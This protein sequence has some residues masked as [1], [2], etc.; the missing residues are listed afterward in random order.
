MPR[1]K[2]PDRRYTWTQKI[3]IPNA[4]GVLQAFFVSFGEYADGRLGEVWIEAHKEGTLVRGMAGALA[5]QA[6]MAIQCGAGLEEV[7][8]SMRYLDFPPH[9]LVVG[10]T[11]KVTHC[12]SLPDYIA[13][14][15]ELAYLGFS[16]EPL[17][18]PRSVG[19]ARRKVD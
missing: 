10:E 19:F 13:Q 9:G 16:T 12:T 5:R 3:K 6:S 18:N 11:T 7:V 14:E 8:K 17:P 1:E 4:Q 2:M 15:I